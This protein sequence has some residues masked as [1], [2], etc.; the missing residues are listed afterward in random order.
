VL[1]AA[2]AKFSLTDI[3]DLQEVATGFD[4]DPLAVTLS[5]TTWVVTVAAEI[6]AAVSPIIVPIYHA[7]SLF[8]VT[9]VSASIPGRRR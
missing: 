1:K 3:A 2:K 7:D 4:I 6:K 9:P 5:K 8:A